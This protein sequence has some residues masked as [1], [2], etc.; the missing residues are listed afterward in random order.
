MWGVELVVM[1]A[2]I[3][4]NGVFAGYEIALASVSLARLEALVRENRAGAKASLM[5]AL[6]INPRYVEAYVN[7]GRLHQQMGQMAEAIASWGRALEL[8]PTHPL[9]RIYLAQAAASRVDGG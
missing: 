4:L 5:R 7:L 2:M 3:L 6:E 8:N 1:L 9:A